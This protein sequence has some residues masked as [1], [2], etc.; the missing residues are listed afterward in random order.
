M[1][2]FDANEMNSEDVTEEN[3]PPEENQQALSSQE[4]Q[5]LI[6]RCDSFQK[7]KISNIKRGRDHE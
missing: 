4:F 2:H 1:P 5:E 7:Y 6:V 3:E